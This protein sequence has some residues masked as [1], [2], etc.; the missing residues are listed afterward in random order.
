MTLLDRCYL[1]IP[2]LPDLNNLR[3]RKLPGKR[4]TRKYICDVSK[5]LDTVEGK[6]IQNNI[7][8]LREYFEPELTHSGPV[9][10][11]AA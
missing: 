11:K 1:I 6:Q 3:T 5:V 9:E 8:L 4:R 10:K 2:W 7:K